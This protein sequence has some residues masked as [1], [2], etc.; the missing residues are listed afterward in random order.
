MNLCMLATFR[1]TELYTLAPSG[2]R[3]TAGCG[4]SGST[5]WRPGDCQ[6][7][8]FKDLVIRDH[9][10]QEYQPGTATAWLH[11]SPGAL[12]TGGLW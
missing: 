12:E 5:G 6:E 7:I 10:H 2:F 9:P 11:A 8:L 4:T 1:L 3:G